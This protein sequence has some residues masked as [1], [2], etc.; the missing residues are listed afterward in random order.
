MTRPKVDRLLS[1]FIIKDR[2][3]QQ[4]IPQL[5]SPTNKTLL[6]YTTEG[7]AYDI[8][9]RSAQ[10]YHGVMTKEFIMGFGECLVVDAHDYHEEQRKL[11]AQRKLLTRRGRPKGSK[12]KPKPPEV[13]AAM[14]ARRLE[15][16]RLA[17]WAGRGMI[18]AKDAAEYTIKPLPSEVAQELGTPLK[19]SRAKSKQAANASNPNAPHPATGLVP[20]P[21]KRKPGRPRKEPTPVEIALN[22]L[23]EELRAKREAKIARYKAKKALR[24]P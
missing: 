10:R 13:V 2:Y 4:L 5:V 3:S 8:A 16:K 21:P 23:R 15:K 7:R 22:Q 17:Y 24:S 1:V 19:W 20:L 9:R 14:T 18:P 12:N 6:T 11:E